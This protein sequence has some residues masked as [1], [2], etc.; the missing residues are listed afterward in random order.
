MEEMIAKI[1]VI[2]KNLQAAQ[3]REKG[4]TDNRRRDL[5]FEVGDHVFMKV[6]PMKGL[7]RF[8]KKEKLSSCFVESFKILE[9]VG[10]AAYRITLPLR[11]VVMHDVFHVLI[12]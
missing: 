12:L 8:E 5:V 10:V 1:S 4:Y 9:R 2:R 6:S 7:L 11:Y 3:S